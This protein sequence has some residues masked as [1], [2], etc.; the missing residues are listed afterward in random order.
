M[1]Q[2]QK[3]Q[4]H[5]LDKYAT[6]HAAW[7]L[8]TDATGQQQFRRPLGLVETSFDSDGTYYGGRAGM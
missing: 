1:A 8:E 6:N 3:E 2:E 5:W 7:N 4:G